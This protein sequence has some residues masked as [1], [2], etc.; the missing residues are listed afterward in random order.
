[1]VLQISLRET[2]FLSFGYITRSGVTGSFGSSIFNFLRNFRT[3]V[4]NGCNDLHSCK[5][6]A[7][8][9]SSPHPCQNLS[10]IFL[11]MAILTSVR[12]YFTVVLI[13]IF[14]MI[15]NVEYLFIC[16]GLLYVFFWE[17]SICVP[18]PFFN[19]VILFCFVLLL[20]CLSS[21]YIL[22]INPLSDRWFANIFPY[23]VG[24]LFSLFIFSFTC[25][26]FL[27]WC[28]CTYLVLLLLPVLFVSYPKTLCPEQCLTPFFISGR[29][30]HYKALFIEYSE[31]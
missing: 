23:S 13:C 11:I 10:S 28:S 8:V 6:C 19:W 1:M 18:C 3:V 16:F 5:Q 31:P 22:D 17:M 14:L 15:R 25:R 24:W 26:R 4:N 27:V 7:R 12:W 29:S 9:P 20:G 21:L 30:W 2:D